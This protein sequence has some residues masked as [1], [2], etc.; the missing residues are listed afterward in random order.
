MS[1]VSLESIK[2]MTLSYAISMWYKRQEYAISL[3]VEI[4]VGHIRNRF[5]SSIWSKRIESVFKELSNTHPHFSFNKDSV[6]EYFPG[7]K[8][9]PLCRK[10]TLPIVTE[11]IQMN[12]ISEQS[13]QDISDYQTLATLQNPV[14]GDASLDRLLT[15]V[16]EVKGVD[17]IT[18]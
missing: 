4:Q 1:R 18:E 10:T 3:P 13:N 8:G 6:L 15:M 14:L 12:K 2:S 17:W 11:V 16:A 5:E 7:H 9:E